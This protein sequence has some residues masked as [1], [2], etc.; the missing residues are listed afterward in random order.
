MLN[1]KG[2]SFQKEVHPGNHTYFT[3]LLLLSVILQLLSKNQD[4]ISPSC[5]MVEMTTSL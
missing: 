4:G 2:R 3:M 5:L 1:E